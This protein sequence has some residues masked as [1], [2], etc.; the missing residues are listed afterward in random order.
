MPAPQ[1]KIIPADLLAGADYAA[2]RSDIRKAFIA[3]KKN[4]RVEVT[5]I[6]RVKK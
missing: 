2:R 4:R 5:L 1:R 6:A 3:V